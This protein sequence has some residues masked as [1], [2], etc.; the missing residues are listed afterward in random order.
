LPG[1]RRTGP[2]PADDETLDGMTM[3]TPAHQVQT[4]LDQ[5]HA[6]ALATVAAA[7]PAIDPQTGIIGEVFDLMI[8]PDDPRLFHAGVARPDFARLYGNVVYGES[9]GTGLTRPMAMAS[10]IG[11]TFERMAVAIYDQASLVF[12]SY[13]GLRAR[14]YLAVHPDRFALY[15]GW[16]YRQPGF[17]YQPLTVDSR[18]HWV[19]GHS[20]TTHEAILVPA[21]LVYMPFQWTSL[22]EIIC[23]TVTT[24]LSCGR[25]PDDALLSGIYEVIERDAIMQMWLHRLGLPK[26]DLTTGEMLPEIVRDRFAPSG[27]AMCVNDISS[28]IP[29]PVA[30]AMLIDEANEGLTV[31]VGAAANLEPDAAVV[32]ALLEAAQGRLW[33]KSLKWKGP[34][35]YR[36]DF[37]DVVTFEDHVR[38]FSLRSSLPQVDFL[39]KATDTRS[40][41]EMRSLPVPA[42]A[43]SRIAA[44]VDA[45]A[46]LD[47]E[48]IAIDVTQPDIGSLGFHVMKAL[49]PGLIDINANH[50]HPLLGGKRLYRATGP[51]RLAS[52]L[53]DSGFNPYPHP[54]P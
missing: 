45:L 23:D 8:E 12:D 50:G 36:E 10:A 9:G 53:V 21:S 39:R 51:E 35:A 13:A 3:N 24:G 15:A 27:I 26:L 28:E 49:I 20:L 52:S 46:T 29:V 44:I 41:P 25:S 18:L 34:P 1:V 33:L 42:T 7:T 19:W 54:F 6:A 17:L 30:F 32:K 16:Q 38:L 31:S 11:E 43:A 48:V 4:W 14:G 40:I 22:S 47:L 5:R 37:R 2:A